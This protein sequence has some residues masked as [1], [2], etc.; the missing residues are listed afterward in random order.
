M[1]FV[2]VTMERQSILTIDKLVNC[3]DQA[4]GGGGGAAA[5]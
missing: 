1:F 5:A 3:Q 4:G 2:R